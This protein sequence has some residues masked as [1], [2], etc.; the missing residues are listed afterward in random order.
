[1]GKCKDKPERRQERK[2]Q[3]TKENDLRKDKENNEGKGA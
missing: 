2:V 3:C 1:M